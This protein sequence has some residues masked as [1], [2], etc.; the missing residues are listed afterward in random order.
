MAPR[1]LLLG[2][3]RGGA[4]T[5][6]G[7]AAR[8]RWRRAAAALCDLARRAG[9]ELID[10]PRLLTGDDVQR[11]LGVAAGPRVGAALAALT[12]AQVAGEV[13]TRGDAERFLAGRRAHLAGETS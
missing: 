11:L 6:A 4:A 1:R 9:P 10:P 8:E 13:R 12:A 3:R 5:A 2:R 7:G